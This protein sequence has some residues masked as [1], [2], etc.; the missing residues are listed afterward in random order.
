M[1][2][3]GERACTILR[4]YIDLHC[5]QCVEH[6]ETFLEWPEHYSSHLVVCIHA[7]PGMI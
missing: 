3:R 1:R 2:M 7:W 6:Y 4:V 5:N